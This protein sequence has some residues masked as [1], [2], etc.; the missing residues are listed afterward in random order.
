MPLTVQLP[1]DVREY[2]EEQIA[3][4]QGETAEEYVTA[5]LRAHRRREYERLKALLL[6]GINSPSEEATP[7]WWAKLEEDIESRIAARQKS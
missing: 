5:V 6:E 2:V 7:E 1:D 4:N 3:D